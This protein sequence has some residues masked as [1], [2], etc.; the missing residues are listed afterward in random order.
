[1]PSSARRS[2]TK[3]RVVKRSNSS[4]RRSSSSKKRTNSRICSICGRTRTKTSSR[5]VSAKRS[6]KNDE[7]YYCRYKY[8]KSKNT[9]VLTDKAG[10]TKDLISCQDCHRQFFISK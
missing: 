2:S 7:K 10:Y 9:R 8:C 6:S 3:K 5:F 1:M 4:K